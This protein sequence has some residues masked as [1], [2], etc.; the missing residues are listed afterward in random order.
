MNAGLSHSADDAA[1]TEESFC[2]TGS[3]RRVP[4]HQESSGP[5][6][7]SS[8][9]AGE[10]RILEDSAVQSVLQRRKGSLLIPSHVTEA[11][12]Q[13][14]GADAASLCQLILPEEVRVE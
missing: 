10:Y 9:A 8:C 11:D 6:Q 3:G 1:H 14:G 7:W 12:E 4:S 2:I 13:S 5:G